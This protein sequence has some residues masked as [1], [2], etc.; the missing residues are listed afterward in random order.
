[1]RMMVQKPFSN[2][3]NEELHIFKGSAHWALGL[4]TPVYIK[5]RRDLLRKTIVES[6]ESIGE[7]FWSSGNYEQ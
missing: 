2:F 6:F 3:V 1:M 5:N 7:L 4:L